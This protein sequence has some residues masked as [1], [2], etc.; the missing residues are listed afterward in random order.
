MADPHFS[1]YFH[2]EN[3][4]K[5][6]PQGVR[7]IVHEVGHA[8]SLERWR[9]AAI[10]YKASDKDSRKELKRQG[11]RYAMEAKPIMDIDQFIARKEYV[12]DYAAD[13]MDQSLRDKARA[14]L[15]AE[16][17]SLWRTNPGYL[18]DKHKELA[19]WIIAQ[20]F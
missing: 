2:D 18:T 15:F 7:L 12:T 6:L 1:E 16:A 11:G 10:N 13:L 14:E 8:V 9:R 4:K 3:S 5:F 19:E 20:S 17:Y